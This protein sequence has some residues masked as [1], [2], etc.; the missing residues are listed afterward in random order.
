LLLTPLSL[1]GL[2]RLIRLLRISGLPRL[3]ALASAAVL[4]I[5]ALVA[6]IVLIVGQKG[7]RGLSH[8]LAEAFVNE[9]AELSR[10]SAGR[11]GLPESA[12]PDEEPAS[13]VHPKPCQRKRKCRVERVLCGSQF[14]IRPLA[15]VGYSGIRRVL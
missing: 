4:K 8:R 10:D 9:A 7:H 5:V 6:L 14:W 15:I 1:P 12:S 13:V 2:C 11:P 3:I